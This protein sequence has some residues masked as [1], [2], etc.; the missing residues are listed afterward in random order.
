MRYHSLILVGLV[1]LAVGCGRKSR[2]LGDAAG[3][4]EQPPRLVFFAAPDEHHLRL[5]FDK[6]VLEAGLNGENLLLE[7]PGEPEV[8]AVRLEPGNEGVVHL[9]VLGLEPGAE[10]RLLA[11]NLRG[12][13]G[14]SVEPLARE[15]VAADEPDEEPPKDITRGPREQANDRPALWVSFNEAVR[16]GPEFAVEL[17]PFVEVEEAGTEQAVGEDVDEETGT[18]D[19]LDEVVV[20]ERGEP[21]EVV[22]RFDGHRLELTPVVALEPGREYGVRVR[23]VTDLAGNVGEEFEWTFSVRPHEAGLTL[24]GRLV[25]AD[26]TALPPGLEVA[27]GDDPEGSGDLARLYPEGDGFTIRGVAEATARTSPFLTVTAEAG[28]Y[29]HRAVYD[30][31]GDGRP[32]RIG[33]CE[34][35]AAR[36]VVLVLRREDVRGPDIAVEP[37]PKAAANTIGLTASALD[38]SGVALIEAFIDLPGDDGEG[39]P[40]DVAPERAGF[41]GNRLE[42]LLALPTADWEP[43]EVHRLYVHARDDAGNWSPFSVLELT[44]PPEVQSFSGRVVRG[45]VEIAGVTLSLRDAAGALL[46]LD[47][48]DEYGRFTLPAAPEGGTVTAFQR[49]ETALLLGR[50]AVPAEPAEGLL[51]LELAAYPRLEELS[52]GLVR[53]Q[54]GGP[55]SPPEDHVLLTARVLAPPETSFDYALALDDARLSLGVPTG[56]RLRAFLRADELPTEPQSAPRLV[57]TPR[58]S[59]GDATTTDLTAEP[60]IL[61][62]PALELVSLPFVELNAADDGEAVVVGWEP[63]YGVAGYRLLLAPAED[64]DAAEL[65][66]GGV[67]NSGDDLLRSAEVRIPRGEITDYWGVPAGTRYVVALGIIGP[68]GADAAWSFAAFIHP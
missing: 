39:L 12:T 9:D 59:E 36:D 26:G 2:P 32:D 64:F 23:G 47:S 18:E 3:E 60:L 30:E 11:R 38:E 66:S 63:Q 31:N 24:T 55:L 53:Y 25:T 58:P 20:R 49:S 56:G 48:S 35:G 10:Y 7:G 1:L 15:F 62:D 14:R 17:A 52:A 16:A 43:D 4:K 5:E 42:A 45:G 27:L 40:F 41:G 22:R 46:A 61:T 51:E 54:R 29:R 28:G 6:P 19:E 50:D 8:V 37:C 33:T 68:D 34:A 13:G 67:W 57:I 44:K 65:P 21:V